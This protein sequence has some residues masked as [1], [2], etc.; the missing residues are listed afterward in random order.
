MTNESFPRPAP[1]CSY[2]IIEKKEIK[3]QPFFHNL[4][5][6]TKRWQCD[7]SLYDFL[8]LSLVSLPSKKYAKATQHWSHLQRA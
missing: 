2:F 5:F 4:F 1:V 6:S 3:N 8:T 7:N